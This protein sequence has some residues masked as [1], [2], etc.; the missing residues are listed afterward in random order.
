MCSNE[1]RA[2]GSPL[3]EGVQEYY[4]RP[5]EVVAK[6]L[7]DQI[8]AWL[9]ARRKPF[10]SLVLLLQQSDYLARVVFR[11]VRETLALDILQFCEELGRDWLIHG[12]ISFHHGL[13]FSIL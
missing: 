7:V 4:W 8:L 10:A 11:V 3:N 1:S 13:G 9:G 5:N 12:S 6:N 2:F